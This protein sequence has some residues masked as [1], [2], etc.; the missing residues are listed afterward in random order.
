MIN[1]KLDRAE[2]KIGELEDINK[3]HQKTLAEKDKEIGRLT[4]ELHNTKNRL[5]DA[6]WFIKKGYEIDEHI[7]DCQE[8]KNSEINCLKIDDE[9]QEFFDKRDTFLVSQGLLP[10]PNETY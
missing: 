4:T 8:C 3:H 1:E 10:D 2:R 5:D 7:T 6:V 9:V